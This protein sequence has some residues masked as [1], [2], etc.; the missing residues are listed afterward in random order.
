ML[1]EE[2]TLLNEGLIRVLYIISSSI[3]T[4]NGIDIKWF[5]CD[6][7]RNAPF[8]YADIINCPF[9]IS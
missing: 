1:M 4:D 2:Q 9:I 3:Y 6:G 8:N 7:D 5:K